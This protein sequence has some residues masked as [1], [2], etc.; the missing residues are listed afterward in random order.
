MTPTINGAAF[1]LVMLGTTPTGG[2]YTFGEFNRM[3]RN[4]GF[5]RNESH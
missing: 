2:A 5:S 4:S 1:A 3:F